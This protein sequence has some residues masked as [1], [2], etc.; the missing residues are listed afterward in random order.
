MTTKRNAATGLTSRET[1]LRDL[2][3]R[4]DG[5]P[6]QSKAD[7]TRG[8]PSMTRAADYERVRVL[9]ARGLVVDARDGGNSYVL[10]ATDRGREVLAEF[11]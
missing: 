11:D 8:L 1:K 9:I 2:L 3:E 5:K 7:L 10:V 4:I 6:G